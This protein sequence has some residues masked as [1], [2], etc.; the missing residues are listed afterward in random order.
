MAKYTDLFSVLNDTD[1]YMRVRRGDPLGLD[2]LQALARGRWIWIVENWS[3][4]LYA[5]F[6]TLANG[7]DILEATLEDLQGLV[8]SY[9]LGNLRNPFDN[10]DTF[11]KYSKFLAAVRVGEL[12][13]SPAEFVLVDKEKERVSSFVIED[14]RAM[15]KYLKQQSALDAFRIGLGDVDSAALYGVQP[16]ARQRS[17]T[18]ADLARLDDADQ[19]RQYIEG[20]IIDLKDSQDISPNLLRIANDNLGPDSPVVFNDAYRSA[21]AVP[22]E[23]SLEHMAKKYLGSAD[24]Y[25]ELV[26]VNKLQPPYI[27]EMGEK[28]VLLAP[29]AVN[30][31]IIAGTRKDDIPVGTKVMI[32]SYSVREEPRIIERV[33]ENTDGT[34]ILFL[35]GAQD[36]VKLRTDEGAFVRIY[37]PHT[38]NTGGFLL[39]P[40]TIETPNGSQYTPKSDEL[41]RIEKSLLTFGVDILRDEATGGLVIDSSCNF[42]FAAGLRNVR[43]AVLY[44]LR[45]VRG[46]LP[47]HPNYGVSASIGDRYYGTADE[48]VIFANVL[49]QGLL[50][51]QRYTDVKIAG[52]QQTGTS[53]ALTIVVW[54]AGVVDPIPL[55]FAS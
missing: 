2:L 13:L 27:D 33:T 15:L 11:V 41:R 16:I 19:I 6:K 54:I 24:L 49:R 14:F 5:R 30:N 28:T 26:T 43:Q 45:T 25:F 4:I 20:I 8:S 35:S 42:K 51:D 39:I 53:L 37:S 29:G 38:I 12:N 22:Y 40:L 34:L 21:V 44:A 50:L 55:S 23:I 31:V 46:E 9:L 48:A 10:F 7:D 18:V 3:N 17:A 47:F 32:G 1:L 36:L 52:I